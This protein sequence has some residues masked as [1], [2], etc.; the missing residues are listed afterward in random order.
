MDVDES[1][2]PEKKNINWDGGE[3]VERNFAED[4]HKCNPIICAIVVCN[5]ASNS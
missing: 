4:A 2:W 3:K 1:R 5:A